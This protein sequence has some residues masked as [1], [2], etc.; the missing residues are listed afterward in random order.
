MLIIYTDNAQA[1][2]TGTEKKKNINAEFA[3]VAEKKE[4]EHKYS[5]THTNLMFF[6]I[7]NYLVVFDIMN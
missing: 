2:W 7:F 4:K 6:D 5:T 3:K 1:D